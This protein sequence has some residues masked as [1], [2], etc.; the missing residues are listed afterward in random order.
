MDVSEKFKGRLFRRGVYVDF[1]ENFV[2][3]K[4][5]R[6]T[7]KMGVNEEQWMLANV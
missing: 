6:I 3:E 1:P 2:M 7:G 4:K 5:S